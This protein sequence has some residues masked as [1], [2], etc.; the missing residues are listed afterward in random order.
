MDKPSRVEVRAAGGAMTGFAA[1]ALFW[2]LISTPPPGKYYPWWTIAVAI[3]GIVVGVV[4][5]ILSIIWP[6]PGP[7]EKHGIDLIRQY[8]EDEQRRSGGSSGG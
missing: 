2:L 3:L 5:I 8:H 1:A 4:T 6:K 7:S